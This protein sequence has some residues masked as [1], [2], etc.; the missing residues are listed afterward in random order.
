MTRTAGP[1]T[2]LLDGEARRRQDGIEIK[3]LK[4]VHDYRA[5]P[6]SFCAALGGG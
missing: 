2:G 5:G 1:G 3:A 4:V 6:D